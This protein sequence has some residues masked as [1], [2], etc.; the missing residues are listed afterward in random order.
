MTRVAKRLWGRRR[1]G[2]FSLVMVMLLLVVVTVLG[3][4]A[5]QLSLVNERG[6]RSDRD[7]EIALQAAEAAL[8]DAELDILGPNPD[9]AARL[10]LFNDKDV[11]PFVEGCG[12]G[13]NLGLCAPTEPGTTPTWMKVDLSPSGA[14]SVPYGSFT[15]QKY[16]VGKGATPAALP[17]YIVEVVRNRGGWQ[18]D[19][20]EN[21]S[22]GRATHIFRVTAI[23]FGVDAETQVVLQTNLYKPVISSGCP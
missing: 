12:T 3:I 11:A 5:A 7:S 22:A 6:A 9:N 20:L 10:C 17:R 4:G 21:A 1:S 18:A 8:I 23:G 2:G 16:L 13:A 15:G 19:R 14:R